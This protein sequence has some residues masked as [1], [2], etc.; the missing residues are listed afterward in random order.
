MDLLP[1]SGLNN[2]GMSISVKT[3]PSFTYLVDFE[4]SYVQGMCNGIIAIRQ[5]IYKILNTPR[6]K[7]VIYDRDY[8]I[9]LDDLIGKSAVYVSAVIKGRIEEALIW[10]NRI[11]SV[12]NFEIS[13]DRDSITV[14]FV[15][16]TVWGKENIVK[17]FDIQGV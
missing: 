6:Y 4:G 7:Y 15:A 8:G 13:S 9:E 1:E 10:D 16:R 17:R 14:S 5:A 11:L 12:E 3:Q 2:E